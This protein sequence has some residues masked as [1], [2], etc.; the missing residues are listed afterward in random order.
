[1]RN[2]RF[3]QLYSFND[4]SPFE[5]DFLLFLEQDVKPKKIVY[6]LFIEP[7]GEKLMT[8]EQEKNKENF[9]KEIEKGYEIRTLFKNKQYKLIGMPFYNE[10]A[11]GKK[12]EFEKK[13]KSV[14]DT[15]QI[16]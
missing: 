4:G 9:L 3:F 6:Q 14:V 11:I 2:E 5:P 15:S 13:F 16:C 1:L 10:D 7:K 8:A 12:D